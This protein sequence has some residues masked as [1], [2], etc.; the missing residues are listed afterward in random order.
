MPLPLTEVSELLAR[1]GQGGPDA[2]AEALLRLVGGLVPLAQCAIFSHE[3][4]G[5]SRL[6]ALGD[7]ARTR[8]LPR[9]AQT[10]A[11]RFQ[12]LDP[13]MAVMRAEWPAARKAGERTPRIV[14]HRQGSG[15]VAHAEYRRQCYERPQVVERLCV[16]ALYEGRRWLCVQLYRG[17]EHGP[18]DAEGVARVEALAPLMVHAVRLHHTGLAVQHG[19]PDVL[20]ARVGRVAPDL[21]PRERDVARALID[22]LDAAAMAARLGLT[23]ESARTATKRLCRK[24]GVSGRQGFMA[25]AMAPSAAG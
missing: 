3:P 15:D 14:L 19:L 13:I 1:L 18:F 12:R 4:G 16:M 11:T 10:Y 5:L 24:L 2:V 21:T 8:D 6:V 17:L 23:T 22:G 25:L 9:I 7:R 20:L